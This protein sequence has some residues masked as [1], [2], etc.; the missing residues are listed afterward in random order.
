MRRETA[1]N[2][3]P[4]PHAT[5]PAGHTFSPL[6]AQ[7]K[8][9]FQAQPIALSFIAASVLALAV[10]GLLTSR[11]QAATHQRGLAHR[12][13]GTGTRTHSHLQTSSA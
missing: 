3:T 5:P 12:A 6:V 13:P 8:A 7:F 1:M 2:T 10:L 9:R 4:Q 11:S